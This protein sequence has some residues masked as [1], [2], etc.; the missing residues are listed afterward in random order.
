MSGIYMNNKTKLM[1]G[2][3]LIT[4][5]VVLSYMGA[6]KMAAGEDPQDQE[7]DDPGNARGPGI[8]DSLPP[9]PIDFIADDIAIITNAI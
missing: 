8:F 1:I 2:I 3:I 9:K 4:G 7:G 6:T 5:I